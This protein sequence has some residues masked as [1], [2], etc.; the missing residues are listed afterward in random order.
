VDGK[1]LWLVGA[2]AGI[3]AHI[4][5]ELASC[6]HFVI[7]SARDEHALNQLCLAFPGRIKS[8]PF[9]VADQAKFETVRGQLGDITDYLDGIIY[10]AGV[11]EYETQLDFNYARYEHVLKVNFLGLVATLAMAK[12]LL[13]KSTARAQL[14][15]L[16]SLATVLAFPRNELYGASKAA[17]DYFLA[18]LR[19]DTVHLPLDINWVRPGF[20]ATRLTAKNDFPMPF[21]VDPAFAARKIVQGFLARKHTVVFPWRLYAVLKL[22]SWLQPLWFFLLRRYLTRIKTW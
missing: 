5:R 21:M 13:K 17:L 1:T 14:C 11:C 2:S 8:L 7:V 9:D 3:G 18:A 16:S 20:V 15:V 12:P 6:G 19:C 10:C 22:M 4:A